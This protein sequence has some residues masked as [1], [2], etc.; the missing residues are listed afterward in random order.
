MASGETTETLT[1]Y[2][3]A[4]SGLP[5][6]E[7]NFVIHYLG[8]ARF[9]GAKAARLA[10]Y[11]ETSAREMARRLLTKVD[12]KEAVA[13]GLREANVTAQHALAL[14]EDHAT[15]TLEDFYTVTYETYRP[16]TT[17]PLWE[18]KVYLDGEI[19]TLGAR[20]DDALYKGEKRLEREYRN[21]QA[22]LKRYVK[23]LSETFSNKDDHELVSVPGEVVTEER[24]KL[25]IPK[26]TKDGKAHLIKKLKW[27]K[28]G[29]E[30]ELHGVQEG[31]LNI[32]KRFGSLPDEAATNV[33]VNV[34]IPD[35]GRDKR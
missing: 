24:I 34:Y 6:R 18:A 21:D 13:A 16:D 15:A 22:R 35:N 19:E 20:I 27:T 17:M 31:V 1:S 25:D 28:D 32:L 7:R 10:G 2:A 26:A 29:P 5:L 11:K 3:D 30:I 14:L 33:N 4:L 9:N 8:D 12:I 23:Y